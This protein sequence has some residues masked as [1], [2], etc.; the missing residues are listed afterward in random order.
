MVITLCKH[1]VPYNSG[2]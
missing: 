1:T 2:H